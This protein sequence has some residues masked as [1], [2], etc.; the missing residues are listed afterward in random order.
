MKINENG[1]KILISN[2]TEKKKGKTWRNWEGEGLTRTQRCI[3]VSNTEKGVKKTSAAI[4][5]DKVATKLVS[6]SIST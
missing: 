2:K 4:C 6:S 1:A 5:T 3:K